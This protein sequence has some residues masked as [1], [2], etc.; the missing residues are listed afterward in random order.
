MYVAQDINFLFIQKLLIMSWYFNFG[1]IFYWYLYIP[2]KG[3]HQTYDPL[4]HISP[5]ESDHNYNPLG[6]YFP[7]KWDHNYDP[8]R[9]TVTIPRERT[10]TSNPTGSSQSIVN[11]WER[12]QNHDPQRAQVMLV[13]KNYNHIWLKIYSL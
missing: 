12:D 5:R 8:L 3:R 11:S 7:R 1:T 4:G 9:Q 10:I 6:H 13:K 2:L